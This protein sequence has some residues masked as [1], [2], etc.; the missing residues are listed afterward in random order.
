MPGGLKE[1]DKRDSEEK[2]REIE[3][4]DKTGGKDVGERKSKCDEINAVL[5]Y[6]RPH[7]QE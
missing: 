2:R 1:E 3:R 6:Q 7:K 4:V 5:Y